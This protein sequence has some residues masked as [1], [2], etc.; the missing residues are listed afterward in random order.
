M[1]EFALRVEGCTGDGI[2]LRLTS[3]TAPTEEKTQKEWK[4]KRKKLDCET[5]GWINA[6]FSE[7][8][9]YFDLA[10]PRTVH[11]LTLKIVHSL[12]SIVPD[13]SHLTPLSVNSLSNKNVYF[14]TFTLWLSLDIVC[15][16]WNPI[17][18][19]VYIGKSFRL[20]WHRCLF[21]HQKKSV[22]FAV[23]LFP[24]FHEPNI[25]TL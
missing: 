14:V 6:F 24:R 16:Q 18:S 25:G 20:M 19:R 2:A 5:A 3:I 21:Q 12:H 23:C 7:Q 22:E 15:N 8:G 9:S 4:K 17:L 11:T 13:A 1:G 10:P